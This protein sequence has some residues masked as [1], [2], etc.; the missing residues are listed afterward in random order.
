MERQGFSEE[1]FYIQY[2]IIY[3][4]EYRKFY[5]HRKAYLTGKILMK[6]QMRTR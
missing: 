5:N 3:E 6:K 4:Q 1:H 2:E